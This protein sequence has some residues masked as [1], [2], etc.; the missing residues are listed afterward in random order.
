MRK[1]SQE[2]EQSLTNLAQ[3]CLIAVHKENIS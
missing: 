2:D 1:N 3:L